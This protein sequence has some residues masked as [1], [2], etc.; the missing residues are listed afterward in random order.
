MST[1]WESYLADVLPDVP[2][3]PEAAA[4]LA[5]RNTAIDFCIKTRIW[6]ETLA[7]VNV[8]AAQANYVCAPAT[9]NTSI[10]T[11]LYGW[12]SD[13]PLNG[14]MSDDDLDMRGFQ[15]R[16]QTSDTPDS[17]TLPD[18]G[19]MRLI[20]IPTANIAAALVA[21][22]ALK[23]TQ[24]A[25]DASDFLFNDWH[26]EIGHGA[27]ARLMAIPNKE[28]SNPNAV[29]YHVNQYKSALTRGR[30]KALKG[31]SDMSLMANPVRLGR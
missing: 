18:P 23:P 31:N 15:W 9:P 4:I 17:F 22:V 11:V 27:K 20:G 16:T 19:T 3:V 25:T 26:E 12:L 2:G 28:W 10:V 6:R 1:A 13:Q 24:T 5:I 7:A 30:T 29:L 14:P 8:V 21:R